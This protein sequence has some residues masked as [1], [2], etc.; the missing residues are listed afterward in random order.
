M[1]KFKFLGFINVRVDITKEY[2]FYQIVNLGFD[3]AANHQIKRIIDML[4]M[5]CL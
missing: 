2:L 3:F 1:H 5:K 4:V